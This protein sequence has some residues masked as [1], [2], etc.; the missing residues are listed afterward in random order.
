VGKIENSRP[1]IGTVSDWKAKY[2]DIEGRKRQ[3]SKYKKGKK[4]I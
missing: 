2:D 4:S 1:V 3:L